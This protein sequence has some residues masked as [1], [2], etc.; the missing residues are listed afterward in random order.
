M[1]GTKNNIVIGQRVTGWK[2]ERARELRSEATI[3]ER[4]L[5]QHLRARRLQGLHFRRQ[6][7]I[8]G[9]IADFYCHSEGLVIEVDGSVHS[10]QEDYDSQR[11]DQLKSR[12]LRILRFSNSDVENLLPEVLDQ[13]VSACQPSSLTRER[14]QANMDTSPNPS[15]NGNGEEKYDSRSQCPTSNANDSD[16]LAS[17]LP[18]GEGPGERSTKHL[19]PTNNTLPTQALPALALSSER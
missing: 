4:L 15:P 13:I 10:M 6:Q 8:D 9:Y 5:W 11:D 12:G 14:I 7:V 2:K 19:N 17:P 18:L 3:S 1:T 16:A